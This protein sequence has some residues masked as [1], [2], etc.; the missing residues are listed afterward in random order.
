MKH[1]A[2]GYTLMINGKQERKVSSAWVTE[3]DALEVLAKRQREIGAGIL[4]RPER[5]LAEVA[6]EYLPTSGTSAA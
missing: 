5:T 2:Y 1:V 6:E 3:T 4:E